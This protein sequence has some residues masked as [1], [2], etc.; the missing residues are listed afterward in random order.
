MGCESGC[1]EILRAIVN[2][3]QCGLFFT[4]GLTAPPR[5]QPDLAPQ[6]LALPA[7]P[8]QRILDVGEGRIYF[9][10][11]LAA[12]A[13]EPRVVTLRR[14]E[15]SIR[16]PQGWLRAGFDRSLLA[17][18]FLR[19]EEHDEGALVVRA[20]LGSLDLKRDAGGALTAEV[21]AVIRIA[22][23]EPRVFAGRATAALDDD[24]V[25]AL[26]CAAEAALQDAVRFV[27]ESATPDKK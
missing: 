22:G 18:G 3:V 2:A 19:G 16:S 11:P 15:R 13:D 1:G 5:P 17:S 7:I 21:T 20:M 23:G 4:P 14:S 27:A 9:L 24:G 6:S 12:T 10:V 8:P 25:I 26:E